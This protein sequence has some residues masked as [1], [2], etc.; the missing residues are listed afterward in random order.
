M[1]HRC[2]RNLRFTWSNEVYPPMDEHGSGK[3]IIYIPVCIPENGLPPTSPCM[4][5]AIFLCVNKGLLG[6]HKKDPV[7]SEVFAG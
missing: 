6:N 1:G 4:P 3:Q 7:Y 2:G 5:H